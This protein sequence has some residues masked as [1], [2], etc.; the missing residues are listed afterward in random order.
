M[1]GTEKAC[2]NNQS[3][4]LQRLVQKKNMKENMDELNVTGKWTRCY[5]NTNKKTQNFSRTFN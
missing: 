4:I 2:M 1:P 3:L 5:E